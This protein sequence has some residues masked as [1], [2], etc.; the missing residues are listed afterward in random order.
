MVEPIKIGR[1]VVNWDRGERISG[2]YGSISLFPRRVPLDTIVKN[3]VPPIPLKP[4]AA[5]GKY[6]KLVAT[7]VEGCV[8]EHIG[9][10]HGV[11]PPQEPPAAGTRIELGEGTLFIEQGVS[12][13]QV[14]VL[15]RD[16]RETHWMSIRALYDAHEQTVD[17]TFEEAAS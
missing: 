14:G 10:L 6:G 1:G 13:D 12:G 17:L 2:R 11:R 7:V 8:S 9:D 5:L 16:G 15:P 4:C 3:E